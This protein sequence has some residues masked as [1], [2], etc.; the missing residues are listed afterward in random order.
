M[1]FEIQLR[2]AKYNCN[3]KYNYNYQM[4]VNLYKIFFKGDEEYG[5]KLLVKLIQG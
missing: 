4:M 5:D 3:L 1:R 2:P